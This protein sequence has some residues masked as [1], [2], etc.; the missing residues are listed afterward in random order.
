MGSGPPYTLY[1]PSDRLPC[2][3][4]ECFVSNKTRTTSVQITDL[5]GIVGLSGGSVLNV[6]GLGY[7][8]PRSQKANAPRKAVGICTLQSSAR[9]ELSCYAARRIQF[10]TFPDVLAR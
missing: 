1:M 3:L 5:S 9:L 2:R 10:L 7:H 6:R 4:V 8:I